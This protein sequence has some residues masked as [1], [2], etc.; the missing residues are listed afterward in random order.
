MKT[1]FYLFVILLISIAISAN[2]QSVYLGT[3]TTGGL[4]NSGTIFRTNENGNYDVLFEFNNEGGRPRYSV[5]CQASNGKL[6]GTTLYGG[7][8]SHGVLFEFDPSNSTYTEKVDFGGSYGE[9]PY[10]GLVAASNGKLYGVTDEGGAS[11]KGTLYEYDPATNTLTTKAEFNSINANSP[12]RAPIHVNGKLYGV[13]YTGGTHGFGTLYEYDITGNTL[14]LKHSFDGSSTGSYPDCRLA[15]GLNGKLYGTASNAGPEGAGVL[16]EYDI[17]NGTVSSIHNFDGTY[18]ST[19]A[20]ALVRATYDGKIY[21]TTRFGGTNEAGVLFSY[22]TQ[23]QTI[24]VVRHLNDATDGNQPEGGVIIAGSGKQEFVCGLTTEGGPYD[25]GTLFAYYPFPQ[26]F[27]VLEAFSSSTSGANASCLPFKASDGNVYGLTTQGGTNNQGVLYKWDVSANFYVKLFD[28]R[29]APYGINPVGGLLKTTNGKYYGTCANGGPEGM[30]TIYEFDPSNDEVNLVHTF[31][32]QNGSNPNSGLMQASNGIIY[33]TTRSGG[34]SYVGTF[35][36]F[37]PALSNFATIKHFTIADGYSPYSPPVQASNGKLYG[38]MGEGGTNSGGAIYEYYPATN[39][40]TK[41]ID[42]TNATGLRSYPSMT[43]G[44]GNTLLGLAS[45]AGANSKGTLFEYNYSTNTLT[46]KIDFDGAN[47][48]RLPI[49]GLLPI[50]DGLYYGV[51]SL[52][53]SNDNGVIYEYNAYTATLTKKI[54]FDALDARYVDGGLL[55]ASDGKFYGVSNSGGTNAT[56]SIFVY[57]S[58][59]NTVDKLHDF[60]METGQQ[61][62]YVTLFE[63]CGTPTFTV[64][65]SNTTTQEGNDTVFV[66][67]LSTANLK[68]KWQENTGS[69]WNDLSESPTYKGTR[70]DTLRIVSPGLALNGAQYRAIATSNCAGTFISDPGALSVTALPTEIAL[71]EQKQF[72]LFPNPTSHRIML[73]GENETIELIDIQDITGRTILRAVGPLPEIDLSAQEA[74]TYLLQIHRTD[75]SRETHRIMKY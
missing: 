75:K 44:P 33:G 5:L 56:G 34:T 28:F 20:G 50:D 11:D 36:E 25:R 10:D 67:Q 48:G 63:I 45:S 29:G 32:I 17:A 46:K 21:G 73:K 43:Q 68:F 71:L 35:F 8:Y 59:A 62:A 19:P 22:D 12:Y 52:G 30:G 66:V 41:K 47:N 4:R 1:P 61:P 14:T 70:N 3:T 16:F 39:T 74:G 60:E 40:Y 37:D 9:D 24:S 49:G 72:L 38:I 2:S 54:D 55:A 31:N 18:G 65:P 13:T 23:G 69:G 7:A 27:T 51:T 6:Y 53:G 58:V 15:D 42:F 64:Q 57:D 26:A